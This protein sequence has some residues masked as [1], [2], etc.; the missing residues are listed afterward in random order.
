[1]LTKISALPDLLTALLLLSWTIGIKKKKEKV[2]LFQRQIFFNK[3]K[4]KILDIFR[5]FKNPPGL[6][7]NDQKGGHVRVKPDYM[8]GLVK[9][10]HHSKF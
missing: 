2:L 7:Y 8:V 3:R 10:Y 6:I 4:T 1:M 5:Y 9:T